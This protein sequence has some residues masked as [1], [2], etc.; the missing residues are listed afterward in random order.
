MC[1][2][3]HSRYQLAC[4]LIGPV[5]V[6]LL[7]AVRSRVARVA[8]ALA[9]IVGVVAR[10]NE[11]EDCS[12]GALVPRFSERPVV[13]AVTGNGLVFGW[14]WNFIVADERVDGLGD[15]F[16]EDVF[17]DAEREFGLCLFEAADHEHAV[18]EVLGRGTRV[19]YTS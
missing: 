3:R 4:P 14:R 1:N 17:G 12:V 18:I 13:V 19:R 5:A 10:R 16:S 8:D 7:A 2:R 6:G 9:D 11:A 15:S